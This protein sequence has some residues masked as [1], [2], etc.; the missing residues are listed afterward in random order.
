MVLVVM[1]FSINW[2]L[3]FLRSEYLRQRL[4]TTTVFKD[5]VT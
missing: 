5:R 4:R 2:V 1:Q 3:N